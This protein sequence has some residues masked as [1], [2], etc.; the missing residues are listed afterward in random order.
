MDTKR[1]AVTPDAVEPQEAEAVVEAV[2]E[3]EAK[4]KR[5]PARVPTLAAPCKFVAKYKGKKVAE[6]TSAMPFTRVLL[7]T[8][9]PKAPTV[10]AWKCDPPYPADADE[11]TRAKM[12]AT[13]Q[14][15]ELRSARKDLGL[16]EDEELVYAYVDLEVEV[17]AT[18]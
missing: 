13:K 18:E 6:R 5:T 16:G 1:N 2:V 15:A 9:D 10:I 7:N 4:P 17:A 14:R 11:A 3:A 12:L 8:A